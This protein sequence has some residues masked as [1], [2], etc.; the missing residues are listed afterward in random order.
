MNDNQLW[1]IVWKCIAVTLCVLFLSVAGCNANRHYQARVLVESG[2]AD[3]LGA[4]CAIDGDGSYTC[5][6][7]AIRDMVNNRSK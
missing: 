4:R 7:L 6:Q 2:K 1:V 3:G 5:Q